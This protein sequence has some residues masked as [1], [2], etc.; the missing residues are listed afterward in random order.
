MENQLG[1]KNIKFN[2]AVTD[3]SSRKY[4]NVSD[5]DGIEMPG[6]QLRVSLR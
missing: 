1:D 3:A 6:S 4:L 5:E 2:P